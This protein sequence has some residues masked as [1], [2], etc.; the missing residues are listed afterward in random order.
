MAELLVGLSMQSTFEMKTMFIEPTKKVSQLKDAFVELEPKCD[1]DD[2]RIIFNGEELRPQKNKPE[3]EFLSGYGIVAGG[4]PQRI[5]F[6]WPDAEKA[7]AK[8]PSKDDAKGKD[9]K[10][11]KK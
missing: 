6:I 8:D 5:L 1:P 10:G 7:K 9:A 3:K 2:L 11:K 4:P